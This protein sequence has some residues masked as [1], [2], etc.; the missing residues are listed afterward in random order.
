MSAIIKRIKKAIKESDVATL[1]TIKD[2]LDKVHS[3]GNSV[4]V[5]GIEVT[6]ETLPPDDLYET[7]VKILETPLRIAAPIRNMR[8]SKLPDLWM[9]SLPKF[10]TIKNCEN[11][12]MMPKFDGVSAGLK[13]VRN[14]DKKVV[15]QLAQTRGIKANITSK[16]M[17]LTEGLTKALDSKFNTIKNFMICIRG[18][19]VLKDTSVT[20][21]APAPYVAGKINGGEDV[22]KEAVENL[23]FIPYEIMRMNDQRPTQEDTFKLFRELGYLKFEP[24]PMKSNTLQEAKDAFA[25]FEKELS[26][27]LD[28]IVYCSKDWSYPITE[29][30]TM[31]A[32]YGKWAWKPSKEEESIVT[33]FEYS[34]SRDGKIEIMITYEEIVIDGKKYSR[35]KIGTTRLLA[36]KGIGV[37][38]QIVVKLSNGISPFIA[39]FVEDPKITEYALPT[40]CPF[41]KCKLTLSKGVNTTLRCKNINCP[42]IKLQKYKNFL[43]V[44]GFKGISD[45]R[46]A[47][48][49]EVCFEDILYEYLDEDMFRKTIISSTV[50]E[51]FQAIG[52]GGKQSTAKKLKGTVLDEKDTMIVSRQIDNVLMVLKSEDQKD[53]F[54]NDTYTTLKRIL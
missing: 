52:Y 42:E 5:L 44:L 24:I 38:S 41:C 14:A 49:D 23:E 16:M 40:Q 54:I 37:G 28:G 11:G 4:I 43:K 22:F 26:N 36:L 17:L 51:L 27:P 8:T 13:F 39:D 7:I 46:L 3:T 1:K 12:I 29:A 45:K 15:L 6:P 2:A 18:E 47:S 9:G 30:E 32:S 20:Q 34:I 35:A 25:H 21:S 48:L 53:D 33:G 10:D 50:N 19:V 31:P